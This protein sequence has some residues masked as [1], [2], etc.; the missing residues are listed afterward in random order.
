MHDSPLALPDL[1]AQLPNPKHDEGIG[2]VAGKLQA[3]L[4]DVSLRDAEQTARPMPS[5]TG[6]ADALAAERLKHLIGT[7]SIVLAA[8]PEAVATAVEIASALGSDLDLMFVEGVASPSAPRALVG[9][10][11]D[12]GSL[13]TLKAPGDDLAPDVFAAQW[14]LALEALQR[15]QTLY[16]PFRRSLGAAGKTAILVIDTAAPAALAFAAIAAARR[17][18]PARLV[19]IARRAFDEDLQALSIEAD[20]LIVLQPL[21][22]TAELDVGTESQISDR[23][24]IG[25]LTAYRQGRPLH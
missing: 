20:E 24:A 11:A 17:R 18:S 23:E 10:I 16:A 4:E 6:A 13:V 22:R 7:P 9:A 5:K 14:R 12:A 21:P 3:P 1:Y 19:L 15:R 25:L 8:A 2:G